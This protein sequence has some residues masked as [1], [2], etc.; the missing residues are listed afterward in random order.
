[1]ENGGV[2]GAAELVDL[3][4][5]LFRDIKVKGI[6]DSGETEND[7]LLFQYGV[8]HWD[9][10]S[11]EYFSFDM[12]RQFMD[13]DEDEPYQLS[14]SLRFESKPF[15]G[16]G[17]YNCWSDEYS[18]LEEF[19]THI[20]ETDGYRTAAGNLPETYQVRFGQC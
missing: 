16:T 2:P 15:Q 9:E 7:M 8:V 17:S 20:K 18:V 11:G 19:V 10:E 1:M 4:I 6:S 13:P 14:F 12:T 5:R 3:S